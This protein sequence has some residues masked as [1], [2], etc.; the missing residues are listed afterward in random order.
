[1]NI[2]ADPPN[3]RNTDSDPPGQVAFLLCGGLGT[4][5][6]SITD[7][8]KAILDVAGWPFLRYQ[9]ESLRHADLDRIVFLTGHGA[10]EVERTFEREVA[11]RADSPPAGEADEPTVAGP[12]GRLDPER[13]F[14][15]EEE[16]LG[17]GGALGHARHL[18][19]RL[20][21]VSNADSFADVAPRDLFAVHRG[22]AALIVAVHVE[23]RFDYGGLAIDDGGRVVGFEEKGQQGPGWI[24]GGVYLLPRAF[25]EELPEAPS[26]LERDHLPR[27]AVEGRL[28]AF[29][30]H[31]FFRDIGTPERLETAQHE[32]VA[33]RR[34]LEATR[35]VR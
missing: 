25:L 11:R 33:I 22:T 13:V 19:G 1:M 35:R 34:R 4:R 32:F 7:R 3:R 8:P 20:N 15:R 17:T 6:R 14:V 9:L 26:S 16:P 10:D 2:S 27:W 29:R 5:L 18:A 21:W 31:G 30:S 23:D 12:A 28:I 24:N